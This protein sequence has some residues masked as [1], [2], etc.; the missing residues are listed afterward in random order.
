MEMHLRDYTPD[1]L[2]RG[3]FLR[4]FMGLDRR[5]EDPT[6]ETEALPADARENPPKTRETAR[7]T[8]YCPAASDLS[9]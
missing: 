8:R 5:L 9:H 6:E 4:H 7:P 2:L 3:R 1:E